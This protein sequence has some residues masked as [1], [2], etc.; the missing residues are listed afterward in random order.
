MQTK[1]RFTGILLP[2]AR[3]WRRVL[4]IALAPF[5]MSEAFAGPLIYLGRSGG[6]ITQNELADLSGIGG[7]SLV[8]VLDKLVAMGLAERQVDQHDKR[9]RRIKL[10]TKGSVL[11]ERMERALDV[12]RDRVLGEV[13]DN[14]IETCLAVMARMNSA[15]E[16]I[17]G[18]S[19]AEVDDDGAS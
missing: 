9:M 5:G 7:P 8:R 18:Q 19:A 6:G 10:T 12:V 16:E 14:D 17:R 11:A 2:M 4:D 13:S 3:N 15:I 1:T